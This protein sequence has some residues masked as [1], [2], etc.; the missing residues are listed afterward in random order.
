MVLAV[1]LKMRKGGQL[2]GAL[3]PV[4]LRLVEPVL[5]DGKVLRLDF[6]ERYTGAEVGLH[7]NNFGLGL[8]EI[9]AR[10]NLHQHQSVLG[11]GIHHIQIATVQAE[12]ADASGNAHVRRFLNQLGAGDERVAG[13]ASLF[14]PQEDWP[15]N[16]SPMKWRSD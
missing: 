11:K 10:E 4:F 6:E 16:Y 2:A 8:E 1:A 5:Q 15:L 14:F 3:L 13:R 12:L 7:V 9:V